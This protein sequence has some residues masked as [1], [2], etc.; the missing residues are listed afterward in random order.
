[1]T[2]AVVAYFAVVGAGIAL[3]A[4][5]LEQG[6]RAA[7]LPRRWA[8]VGALAF[9]LGSI[10]VAPRSDTALERDGSA[11]SY[12][13]NIRG[14]GPSPVSGEPAGAKLFLDAI[15]SSVASAPGRMAAAVA[16]GL[17]RWVSPALSL[18]WVATSGL[19]LL[20]LTVVQVKYRR[21]LKG[22]PT[23]RLR[24]RDVHV[25][26]ETGPA[27]IGIWRPAIVLPRSLLG[28]SLPELDIVLAH[29]EE[30]LTAR[31]NWLLTGCCAAAV[32]LPWHPVSWWML[33][34]LRLAVEMDCDRRV[35][36]RGVDRRVYGET[37]IGISAR[38]RPLHLGVAALADHSTHLERRLVA[39]STASGSFARSRA[40]T[41]I[42]V[43]GLIVAAAC[44][45]RLPTSPQIERMDVTAAENNPLARIALA[46]DPT[47][48]YEVDGQPVAAADARGI[49]PD[50]I[51]SIEV[52]K[53]KHAGEAS[54]IRIVTRGS[55]A[56]TESVT[57]RAG[58]TNTDATVQLGPTR[59]EAQRL[60]S[61]A[62]LGIERMERFEGLVLID[63]VRS[64]SAALGRL[65]PGS[66]A[67]I[68]VLKGSA[69]T[70]LYQEPEAAKGV[71]HVRM[72]P[73][74]PAL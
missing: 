6:L 5:V 38:Y 62:V 40:A 42:A 21:R 59:I 49:G 43:S 41:L 61:S 50:R 13:A 28:Q 72:K 73:G 58:D 51:A 63:G 7:D 12:A 48:N 64:S 36:R 46:A 54:T 9:L 67:S 37:L 34:R 14:E 52:V 8:W 66:V 60:E 23:L 30:H 2:L 44:E 29:E 74:T 32:L 11:A 19:L 17:P 26:D 20:I 45:A 70:S 1:V 65:D 71:I 68:E 24:G 47:P 15:R 35:L 3:A 57:S 55:R 31:D 16:G 10:L 39:M 69:A 22:W 53:G 18:A 56:G 25:S 33:A 27:V 4:W